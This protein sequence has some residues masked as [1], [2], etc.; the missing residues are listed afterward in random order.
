MQF[1]PEGAYVV[2]PKEVVQEFFGHSHPG[3]TRNTMSKHSPGM[4]IGW[5]VDEVE[6]AYRSW[7]PDRSWPRTKGAHTRSKPPEP[8]A[9]APKKKTTRRK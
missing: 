6:A 7:N 3:S 9:P 5:P 1:V 8:E 4:I 2:Y